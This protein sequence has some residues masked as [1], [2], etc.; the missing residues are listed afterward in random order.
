MC[1]E[2]SDIFVYLGS[3]Y[4]DLNRGVIYFGDELKEESKLISMIDVS[5]EKIADNYNFNEIEEETYRDILQKKLIKILKDDSNNLQKTFENNKTKVIKLLTEYFNNYEDFKAIIKL[6][7]LLAL[8]KENGFED[9]INNVYLKVELRQNPFVTINK[10]M[11]LKSLFDLVLQISYERNIIKIISKL[12]HLIPKKDN[13]KYYI[14]EGLI[15]YAH[16]EGYSY[17]R[18]ILRI[19]QSKSKGKKVIFPSTMKSIDGPLFEDIDIPEIILNDGLEYIG[20]DAL[21]FDGKSI[22]IPPSVKKIRDSFGK[23]QKLYSIIFDDY[24][25]SELLKDEGCKLIFFISLLIIGD[26]ETTSYYRVKEII[27]RNKNGKEYILNLENVKF[28]KDFY[29]SKT[30]LLDFLIEETEKICLEQLKEQ[31]FPMGKTLIRNK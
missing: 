1:F 15:K 10:Y 4:S 29:C 18:N 8:E 9:L 17:K 19:L 5:F 20:I 24:E 7:L 6:K 26:I 28:N 21:I 12:Y 14:P 23:K 31:Q 16:Y 11:T 25:N 2:D 13:D 27:L 22:T 30:N 3:I